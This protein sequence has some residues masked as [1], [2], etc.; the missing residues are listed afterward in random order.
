MRRKGQPNTHCFI[1]LFDF[2]VQDPSTSIPKGTILAIVITSMTYV[3]MAMCAGATVARDATG[4]VRDLFNGSQAFL[5]CLPEQCKYGLHNSF[6]VI[7]L[8][9]VFGPL[10]YAGC[11][12]ATLS[13]ALASLVSA[14]KV[15]QVSIF[16]L[17]SWISML[18]ICCALSRHCAKTSYTR[19]SNGL[20]EDMARTMNHFVATC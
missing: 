16:V 19:K 14:P 12:A 9:S 18:T 2:G 1:D 3:L 7:E 6:E 10:I 11:F 15:F 4:N 17:I 13:S 20:P 8:V 5:H